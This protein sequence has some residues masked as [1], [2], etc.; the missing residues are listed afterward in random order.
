MALSPFRSPVLFQCRFLS[1]AAS[2]FT[3]SRQ[4]FDSAAQTG[5]FLVLGVAYVHG[6]LGQQTNVPTPPTTLTPTYDDDGN[7]LTDGTGKIYTWDCENRLTQVTLPNS[8]I[9]R[10]YY[11]GISRR[12]KREHITPTKTTTTTYLY[13]GWN[14]IH[15]PA[16]TV[17][18]TTNPADNS[19]ITTTTLSTK[20]Y[21]WGL[22]LSNTLQSA[23]GVGGLLAT[24]HTQ[25]TTLPT[26]VQQYHHT[27]DANGNT[28]ELLDTTSG[29]TT[30]TISA[31]Y[32]YDAFGKETTTTGAQAT[33]NTYRFSTKPYDQ[34]TLLNYYGYRFYDPE[35]GRWINK[36][37]ISEKGGVN[38]YGM[39]NNN[40]LDQFDILGN[41]AP[42]L[43]LLGKCV[44]SALTS[45]LFDLFL[46]GGECC[47]KKVGLK[48]LKCNPL[49][50]QINECEIIVSSI[51]G[52]LAGPIPIPAK[53]LGEIGQL[54]GK[55]AIIPFMLRFAIKIVGKN[56]VK[57]MWDKL[58]DYGC[59]DKNSFP[60]DR[61]LQE[62]DEYI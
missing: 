2:L 62:M 19:T 49:C 18:T 15:E 30:G 22:D 20:S 31:H 3:R 43:V 46:Q 56:A 59:V 41:I 61:E 53:L 57:R 26:Q 60:Q 21:I 13:D 51:L 48:F 16:T 47:Y 14:V 36:D 38:L 55:A 54:V 25:N 37:P 52:C 58:S 24:T 34:T 27:Y 6:A 33:T 17:E 42:A 32:E 11:D 4:C 1:E 7:T 40:L 35:T 45:A 8:E 44:F 12:I 39:L 10:Y 5:A 28:S 50:C 29:A 23:G 9:V